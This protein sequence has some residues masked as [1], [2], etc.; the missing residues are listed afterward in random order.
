MVDVNTT[1]LANRDAV[2]ELIAAAENSQQ[3][4]TVSPA[5]GKWSPSQIVEHVTRT[6]DE[7]AKVMSGAPSKF[8]NLQPFLRPMLRGFLFN[9]VLRNNAFPKAKTNKAMDPLSGPAT[10]AEYARF[11]EVHTRHHCKQM[12]TPR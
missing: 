4:W 2:G 11:I 1:L 3:L 9:R 6:L 12:P 7:S 8:P 10:V 5:P